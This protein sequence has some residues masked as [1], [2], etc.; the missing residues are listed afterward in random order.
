[1]HNHAPRT[2]REFVRQ[3]RRIA[4]GHYWLRAASGYAVSTMHWRRTVRLALQ[5]LTAKKSKIVW[6]IGTIAIEIV[7][8]ALGWFDFRMKR[9]HHVW[10]VSE[11]TKA[12]M[13]DEIRSMYEAFDN[14]PIVAEEMPRAASR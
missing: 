7:S 5:E 13:T 14:E 2:I 12:V 9:E 6:A 3:R 1:V 10:K 11:T 4:A 8:R